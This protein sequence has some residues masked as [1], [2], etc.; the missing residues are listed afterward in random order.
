MPGRLRN[1]ASH[2]R[3]VQPRGVTTRTSRTTSLEPLLE[4]DFLAFSEDP[5]EE[6]SPAAA[7]AEEDGGTG[8]CVTGQKARA[9]GLQ[10]LD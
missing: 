3:P 5:A 1:Q 4:E 8:S 2:L 6:L 10:E 7:A 9:T